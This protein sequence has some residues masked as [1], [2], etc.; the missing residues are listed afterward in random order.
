MVFFLWGA[1]N[2]TWFFKVAW[3]LFPEEQSPFVSSL[4]TGVSGEGRKKTWRGSRVVSGR[5]ALPHRKEERECEKNFSVESPLCGRYHGTSLHC[6]PLKVPPPPPPP[7]PHPPPAKTGKG[8]WKPL[9][10]LTHPHLAPPL[11]AFTTTHAYH[12]HTHTRTH[13]PPELRERYSRSWIIGDEQ[14]FP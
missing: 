3:Q 9:S 13:T 12:T 2:T 11:L 5:V 14:S 6:A 1:K 8:G 4:G 10:L 7:P